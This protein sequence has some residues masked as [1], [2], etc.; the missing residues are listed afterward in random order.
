[1]GG[2]QVHALCERRDDGHSSFVIRHS[3][4]VIPHFDFSL[5]V[6]PSLAI[7]VTMTLRFRH[8]YAASFGALLLPGLLATTTQAAT[9]WHHPLSLGRGECWTRRIPI[10]VD[11][12]SPA[13]L[14]GR[15]LGIRVGAAPG[16]AAIAGARTGHLRLVD[17]AGQEL[18]LA[19][20]DPEGSPLTDGIVP[21]DAT[22][23]VPGE[24][25]AQS[26]TTLQLYFEN[27]AAWETPDFLPNASSQDF[28]GGFETGKGDLPA[29]WPAKETTPQH[30]V[31][32]DRRGG[33]GGSSAIR[34]E[35][36][37]G[38]EPNWVGV[39]HLVSSVSP[40]ATYRL[41]AWT[42]ASG[43]Q[44]SSGWFVHAG[45]PSQ[46]QILNKTLSAGSGT[47]DWKEIVTEF[48]APADATYLVIGTILRGSGTAWFD[49]CALEQIDGAAVSAHCGAVE[50]LDLARRGEHTAWPDDPALT[51]A[52]DLRIANAS[53]S[54]L[55][56]VL[57]R[58]H[59]GGGARVPAHPREAQLRFEDR[60]LPFFLV[61]QTLLFPHAIPARTLDTCRFF[62][63]P[64]RAA[65]ASQGELRADAILP[66]D[67]APGEAISA[68]EQEAYARLLA[69]AA[70]LVQNP[71]FEEGGAQPAGWQSNPPSKDDPSEAGVDSG[72]LFGPRCA[73]LHVPAD[74]KLTWR[75][76]RQRVPVKPG[77]TYL[78]A[79]WAR[80]QGLTE[81]TANLHAHL[82]AASG[83]LVK[84][85]AFR[86]AGTAIE[87]D[88][89]WTLWQGTA[90]IP[91]DGAQLELHLTMNAKGTLWHD[92]AF[93]SEVVNAYAGPGTPA[94][95]GLQSPASPVQA[96]PVNAVVKVFQE[97][98]PPAPLP[99]SVRISLA[100]SEAEPLQV[101]LRAAQATAD[102]RA[103]VDLP[104]GPG[105]A[106]LPQPEI[107]RVGYVPIDYPT[108]YYQSTTP[109]WHRK[110]PTQP[111]RCD[112]WAG[113][114]PD[115]LLPNQPF[116]LE[117]GLTQPLWL[118][119]QAPAGAR[120]GLYRCTLRL[121]QN[122]RLL[123]ELPV[124]V[125]VRP[126]TLP[127]DS[128]FAAIYDLRLGRQWNDPGEPRE[129]V[130]R[131]VMELMKS[132]RLC[133][134][135]PETNPAFRREGDQVVAD[136]TAYDEEAAF[137]F[138]T[139]RFPRGYTPPFF[140]L[141][142]WGHPPRAILGEQP[143]EGGYPFEGADRSRLRPEYKKAYQ[144]CLRL[145]WE[146]VKAKGWADRLVLYISD[147]PHFTHEHIRRQMV[148][149]CEMI[150]EVD[151]EIPVF[152]ST[153]RHCPDWDGSLD[154]WGVGHYGCF[155]VAEMERRKAA[156]DRIWFTTD[157]QMCTD[158]PYCAVERLLPHYSFKYGAEAY[159]FWGVG[160]LTYDPYRYGWH[161]YIH[162]SSEPGREFYVRYPNGDGYLLYPGKPLGIDG[163][164]SSIRFE[165]AREGVEDYEYLQLL[166]G[167]LQKAPKTHPARERAKKALA[168]AAKL[169][170]IPNAGGRYSSRFL[171]DPDAVFRVREQLAQAITA[172]S[173]EP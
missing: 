164:V 110:S 107:H 115:P 28:N 170:E 93:V 114:W 79:V 120:P 85:N 91:A 61:G 38:A 55:D 81:G 137:Y 122:D 3:G 149:L 172:L 62:F 143:Y 32:W 15:H 165:Q 105:G 166:S 12:P 22:L 37:A 126:F 82:L 5:A 20:I 52:L 125:T 150:H 152:S 47:F 127:A 21:E 17:A 131:R 4:F 154:I 72:G 169:V 65:A 11:N 163:P 155:D 104:A 83:R 57:V 84:E 167:L 112:G 54:P 118:T 59:L 18:L 108:S 45:K 135:R 96:W 97:D 130:R 41:R 77:S 9:P 123:T 44:G 124:E 36:D 101:A 100:R 88:T 2:K 157:G 33:R 151:P 141:F 145:Y 50:T 109:V 139:M 158:T 46:G 116:A 138:D 60:S 140:Y 128:S 142:G 63:S 14:E 132:R 10:V 89:G 1:M 173:P 106:T 43:V 102:V 64:A 111:P 16:Q 66:S 27:P 160:W 31:T 24:C 103:E 121:W 30:R 168:E 48:A 117:T 13:P 71:A 95:S 92:G 34:V 171:P 76:W 40:G 56:P 99:A 49:D 148:A 35:A 119:F 156:G 146:H 75:G 39:T 58:L 90:E 8:A 134:D 42:K 53:A 23:V 161:S 113:W 26:S 69:S 153:W 136:F 25:P 67:Y 144:E 73:R 129:P 68:P 87:G 19:V 7:V 147:E 70:N 133:P 159:E 94:A 86:S 51:Q 80:C 162:Q 74:A 98:P 29:G 6:P 78:Y